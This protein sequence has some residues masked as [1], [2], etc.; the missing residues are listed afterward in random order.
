MKKTYII[1]H[2]HPDTDSICSAIGYA[3]LLNRNGLGNYIPAC[4][5]KLNAE[6]R[7]ALSK[8]GVDEPALVLNVEPSV[9]D[10][11]RIHQEKALGS[12]PTIDV[13][14]MMDEK[15]MRNLPI[16]DES[17]KLLGLVS[18]HGLARAYVSNTKMD[19]LAVSPIPVE[20]LTRILHGEIRVKKHDV[21]EGAVYISIDALHVILSRIT[22]K[23]IAIVG[24]DEPTQLA[25]VSAGIAA[26]IIADSAPVGERLLASAEA[27]GVTVIATDADAFGVANLIHLTLPAERIMS[28][29]VPRVR[30]EDTIE[31]V[32][33]VVS[34]AKYRAAC[35]VDADGKLIGT[36]SR[37]TLMEDAAK[38]VI[39]L[40]HNEYG[41][42]V[43]GIE[44]ADIVEIIDHHRLGAMTTLKPIRFDMEPVG[45]TSTI[46]AGR[47]REAGITPSKE[48]AGV[49]LS[50][51][52]SDT[53]GLKMSTT[54]KKDVDMVAYLS[55]HAEVDAEEYAEELISEGMALAGMTQSALLDRDTKELTLSAKRVI[56]AQVLVPSYE[57]AAARKDEIYE[58][59]REKLNEPHAPDMY[60]ALYTSVSEMGSDMF[61]VADDKLLASAL[62]WDSPMHLPGV[63]SRK[64]DFVPKFGHILASNL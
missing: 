58:A 18:E 36:I 6:S 26:L 52:L 4:C 13:I 17:G 35:V 48:I 60:I 59:L 32:Q 47:F 28:T 61:A 45:S 10:L 40:D 19:T 21:L 7:Y 29:D 53:L 41:Q 63:V 11:S 44:T 1:G 20:T 2:R 56:I 23:D 33:Q 5:G 51:I 62:H 57:Y 49:L 46:I 24:D 3:D 9:S 54:T 8:F 43:Q 14:H 39:L 12:T 64:K 31:Y 30:M 15:D 22:E 27:R 25:L 38:A 42:A 55:A 16:I 34:N 50:G 37:N